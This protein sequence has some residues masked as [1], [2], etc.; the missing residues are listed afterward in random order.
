MVLAAALTLTI[1]TATHEAYVTGV[2]ADEAERLLRLYGGSPLAYRHNGRAI[3]AV[4]FIWLGFPATIASTIILWMSHKHDDEFGPMSK[5]GRAAN[6]FPEMT[7]APGT[8]PRETSVNPLV[9][10]N[11][12]PQTQDGVH[13]PGATNSSPVSSYT[14]RNFSPYNGEP[15][16][17]AQNSSQ[18]GL[19]H[20]A[21]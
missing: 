17:S 12:R 13:E 19:E 5:R 7:G 18:G 16:H 10:N 3:A 4:V 11:E 20:S 6:K 21:A 9:L 14:G 1:I 8:S 2:N 15:P